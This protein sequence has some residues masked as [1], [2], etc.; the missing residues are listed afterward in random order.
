MAKRLYHFSEDGQISRFEPRPVLVPSRRAPGMEWLNGPLVWAIDA[1]HSPLY[2]FP[3]DCPRIVMWP[4]PMS[5][6]DDIEAYWN[7]SSKLMAAFFEEGWLDRIKATRLFRYELP[8]QTFTS[9]QDAGM[10][11]SH[12][13]VTPLKVDV[14]DD[15]LTNLKDA[16]VEVRPLPDLSPLKD[17]WSTSL[18][19]SGI[20]LRHAKNWS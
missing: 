11:V 18:H 20:R 9:L 4:L 12:R 19:V 5:S 15:L 1:T 8:S 10:H 7:D 2:L 3:R 13:G 17:A 14:V 16:G 6:A